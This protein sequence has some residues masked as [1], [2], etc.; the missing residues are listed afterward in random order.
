MK[1]QNKKA[2][3]NRYFVGFYFERKGESFRFRNEDWKLITASQERFSHFR[4][5]MF[6]LKKRKKKIFFYVSTKKE[7][8]KSF[9]VAQNDVNWVVS[10]SKHF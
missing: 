7:R 2:L 9:F 1:K 3:L 8:K 6:R 10:F 5:E 4:F